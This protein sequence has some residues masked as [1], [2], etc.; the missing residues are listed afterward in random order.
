MD[1]D[2]ARMEQGWKGVE[3]GFDWDF[4]FDLVCVLNF[5]DCL[6]FFIFEVFIVLFSFLFIPRI[7][8]RF[9]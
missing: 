3:Y 6:S 7:Y 2:G 4:D 8:S 5:L 1:V 9:F